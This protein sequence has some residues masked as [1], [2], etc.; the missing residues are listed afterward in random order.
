MENKIVKASQSDED[1]SLLLPILKRLK[2]EEKPLSEQ[3]QKCKT[4]FAELQKNCS[5]IKREYENIIKWADIYENA[6]LSTK[7]IIVAH[8]I[9]NISIKK[10]YELTVDFKIS[11]EQFENGLEFQAL[12]S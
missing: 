5:E 8:L 11:S 10:G 2:E 3:V 7:Q 12:S 9:D 4:D 6:D 1:I